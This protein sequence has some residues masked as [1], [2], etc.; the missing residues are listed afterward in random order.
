MTIYR[1]H[2]IFTGQESLEEGTRWVVP[3]RR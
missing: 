3:K 1:S 2:P